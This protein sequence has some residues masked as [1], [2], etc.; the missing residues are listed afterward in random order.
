MYT[1]MQAARSRSGW[2]CRRRQHRREGESL[3]TYRHGQHQFWP[4]LIDQ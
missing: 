3:G 4:A 1:C 2:G